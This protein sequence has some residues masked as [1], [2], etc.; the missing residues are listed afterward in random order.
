LEE[1]EIAEEE[2]RQASIKAEISPE[3]FIERE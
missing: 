2:V 1:E 3:K